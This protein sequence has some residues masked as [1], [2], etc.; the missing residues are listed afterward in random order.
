[1]IRVHDGVEDFDLNVVA[2]DI[3]GD[4]DSSEFVVTYFLSISDSQN[5]INSLSSPYT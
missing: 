3:L 4:Q 2:N 5:N 1:M